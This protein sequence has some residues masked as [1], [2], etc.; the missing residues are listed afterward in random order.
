MG[1]RRGRDTRAAVGD[2]HLHLLPGPPRRDPDLGAG[3]GVLRRV[4]D[5][6]GE[7][8]VD[9]HGVHQHRGQVVRDLHRDEMPGGDRAQAAQG[10]GDQRAQV[11][12][13]LLRAQAAP[14]NAREVE[15]VADDPVEPLRLLLDRLGEPRPLRVAPGHV[16][17]AQAAGGG[18]DRGEG[19]AQVVRHAVEEGVLQLVGAPQRL[20]LGGLAAQPGALDRQAELR[21]HRG[22]QPVVGDGEMPLGGGIGE[23]QGADAAVLGLHRDGTDPFRGGGPGALLRRY[24][25]GLL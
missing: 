2:L 3:R 9:L 16:P 13:A 8:L 18:D 21:R 6:V 11:V 4:L 12:P 15:Q 5:Q 23:A 20:R 7:D 25:A 22:Q 14:L 24:A 19:R 10:V 17:L 1:E